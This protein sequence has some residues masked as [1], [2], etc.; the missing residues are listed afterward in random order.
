MDRADTAWELDSDGS[1]LWQKLLKFGINKAL[2][3]GVDA[4]TFIDKVAENISQRSD[5]TCM[6][7]GFVVDTLLNQVD[8]CDAREVP[9]GLVEYVNETLRSSYPPQPRNKP[10]LS[11]ML[12]TLSNTIDKCPKELLWGLLEGIQEGLSIWI[13]DEDQALPG[14]EYNDVGVG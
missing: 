2:D 11:W 6:S 14:I 13:L 3:Y 5:P 4:V 12:R 1:N 7:S 10:S 8:I 9:D